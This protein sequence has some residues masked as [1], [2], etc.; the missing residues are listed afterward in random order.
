MD[1]GAAASELSP[2]L[3]E[4]WILEDPQ[5]HWMSAAAASGRFVSWATSSVDRYPADTAV[6]LPKAELL[7]SP[8]FLLVY[9]D[10]LLGSLIWV[11]SLPCTDM[12][13]FAT[14]I[15]SRSYKHV[16]NVRWAWHLCAR[17]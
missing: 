10:L 12:P 2:K 8:V 4:P 13:V 17:V 5:P 1:Y 9:L 16:S 15:P 11:C 7:P 14:H 6:L 3:E